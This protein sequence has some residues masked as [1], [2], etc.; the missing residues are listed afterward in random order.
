M[1]MNRHF[2][3][4]AMLHL[5]R[6][7]SIERSPS[8]KTPSHSHA[9]IDPPTLIYIYTY[10]YIKLHKK[11]STYQTAKIDTFEQW[12]NGQFLFLFIF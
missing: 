9:H 12:D 7:I 3:V 6:V 2:T 8:Q 4:E 10:I 5:Y 1:G 11:L